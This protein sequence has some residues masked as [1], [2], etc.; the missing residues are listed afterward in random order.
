MRHT[1]ILAT[2]LTALISNT[3]FAAD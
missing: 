2:A 1:A 3:A